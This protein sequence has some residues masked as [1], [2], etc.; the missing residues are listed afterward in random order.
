M[1]IH[2]FQNSFKSTTLAKPLNRRVFGKLP[3]QSDCQFLRM[4]SIPK[5]RLRKGH[6]KFHVAALG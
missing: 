5:L 6:R 4:L 1:N 2:L 3:M